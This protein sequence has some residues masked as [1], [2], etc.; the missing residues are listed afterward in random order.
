MRRLGKFYPSFEISH[1][2]LM[3]LRLSDSVPVDHIY[4][5]KPLSFSVSVSDFKIP[6]L[7]SWQVSD[8]PFATP[9][10]SRSSN[11]IDAYLVECGQ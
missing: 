1:S 6:V 5:F 10:I 7:A 4:A 11:L 2:L 8:L 9:N 3:G